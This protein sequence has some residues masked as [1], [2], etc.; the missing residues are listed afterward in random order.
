M[1]YYLYAYDNEG[2]PVYLLDG[3]GGHWTSELTTEVRLF[4]DFAQ[5]IS[6]A[7]D[8]TVLR[9]KNE[10]LAPRVRVSK[11]VDPAELPTHKNENDPLDELETIMASGLGSMLG[12]MAY[13]CGQ[14]AQHC[15]HKHLSDKWNE[16]ADLLGSLEAR[17]K[18]LQL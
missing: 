12:A 4:D 15:Q 14:N 11:P 7:S 1:K 5:A 13:I 2:C 9:A 6:H 10:W 3:H 8:L 18:N 17:A 16:M